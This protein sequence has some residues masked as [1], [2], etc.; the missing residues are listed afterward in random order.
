MRRYLSPDAIVQG[1]S[2]AGNRTVSLN[3]PELTQ[4]DGSADFC[5]SAQGA[6]ILELT[7]TAPACADADLAALLSKRRLYEKMINC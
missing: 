2:L 1:W 4:G 3:G 7:E 6:I 5:V